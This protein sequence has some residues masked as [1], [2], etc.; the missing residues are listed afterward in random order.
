MRPRGVIDAEEVQEARERC[1][2]HADAGDHDAGA[3]R[4]RRGHA[5]QAVDEEECGREIAGID[6]ELGM[7]VHRAYAFF[8]WSR[9]LSLGLNISSMRSVTT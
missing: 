4:D 8:F 3:R 2:Q 9:F 1:D 5:L 7:Q 6:D